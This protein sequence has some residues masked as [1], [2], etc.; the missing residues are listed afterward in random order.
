MFSCFVLF[1]CFIYWESLYFSIRLKR[2]KDSSLPYI[3]FP[4]KLVSWSL[5]VIFG[6]FLTVSPSF[7][8]FSVSFHFPRHNNSSFF[9]LTLIARWFWWTWRP[10]L[11]RIK[12]FKCYWPSTPFSSRP[13]ITKL[14]ICLTIC[15]LWSGR[16]FA[17]AWISVAIKTRWIF[18][19]NDMCS[20]V[21]LRRLDQHNQIRS[22]CFG[23]TDP[24]FYLSSQVSCCLFC[25]CFSWRQQPSFTNLWTFPFFFSFLLQTV[26]GEWEIVK[27]ERPHS[28]KVIKYHVSRTSV[29]FT[30]T[31]LNWF[32]FRGTYFYPFVPFSLCIQ[33]QTGRQRTPTILSFFPP[34]TVDAWW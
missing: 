2:I 24:S 5:P 6:L 8:Q 26:N 33:I 4:K 7:S 18:R 20:G 19:E 15:L 31:L 1:P 22:T 29:I 14:F 21:L 16:W 30:A 3:L 12:H 23:G 9:H 32:D 28:Q 27:P 34:Q 25:L 11:E 17:G 10:P 13:S